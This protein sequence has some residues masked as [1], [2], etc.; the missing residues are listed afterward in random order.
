MTNTRRDGIHVMAEKSVSI[1]QNPGNW[2]LIQIPLALPRR[3]HC[4][5]DVGQSEDGHLNTR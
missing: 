4:Q 1:W 3:G 2:N 5:N